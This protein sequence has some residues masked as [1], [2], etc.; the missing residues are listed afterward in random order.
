MDN[1]ILELL[2]N[3]YKQVH[4]CNKCHHIPNGNIRFDPEKV[5]RKIQPSI[6]DSRI[7]IV[8]Q[9]LAETQVRVSGVPYHDRLGEMSKGGKF[10]EKY[11]NTIGYTLSPTLQS[12]KLVY[13][14]DL[15]Q[16]YPG[17]NSNGTGDN[18]PTDKEIENCRGWLFEELLL[19]NPLVILLFGNPA[20]KTF[21]KYY[22]NQNAPTVSEHYAKFKPFEFKQRTIFVCALPHL[23]S[24]VP[25][26]SS[27]FEKAF[28]EMKALL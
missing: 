2:V 1:K 28:L 6:V 3:C 4:S 26:K 14:T 12:H 9:S 22:M 8:G 16:C 15:V 5:E 23:T 19:L 11:L 13:T 21:F 20:I 10:L 25:S 18:I 24:M 7:F 27:I 17:K